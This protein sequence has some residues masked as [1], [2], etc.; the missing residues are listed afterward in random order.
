MPRKLIIIFFLLILTQVIFGQ[1]I[2]QIQQTDIPGADNT[3]PSLYVGQQ[4]TISPASIGAKG[5]NGS[6][7]NLFAYDLNDR[8]WNGIY[9]NNAT[10]TANLRTMVSITGTVSENNGMTELIN[11]TITV[12]NPGPLDETIA[13]LVTVSDLLNIATA[14]Q[15]E[16]SLVKINNLAC[17]EILDANNWYAI[18][19]SGN[20]LK[21]GA[22]FH[23]VNQTV[24]E[25]YGS[26]SGILV[27]DGIEF[28]LHPRNQADLIASTPATLTINTEYEQ[29]GSKFYVH[30]N[31]SNIKDSWNINGFE[32]NFNFNPVYLKHHS[33]QMGDISM[34]DQEAELEI[35]DDNY[36]ITYKPLESFGNYVT[37]R[38]I[39]LVFDVKE[40]GLIKVNFTSFKFFDEANNPWTIASPTAAN[41]TYN[42]IYNSKKAYLSIRNSRNDKNIFNPYNNERLIIKCGFKNGEDTKTIVRIYDLKGR[43][44]YTPVNKVVNGLL[45]LK[46]DGRDKNR[47]LV[48]IGTYICQVEVVIRA[49]GDKYTTDQPI[50]VAGQL[51]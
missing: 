2:M 10:N 20:E 36:K 46:W 11:A 33:T 3:Y 12:L 7:K 43:L 21:I 37:P 4:V 30:I 47:E 49:T 38:L 5:F 15:Y 32:F 16:S 8:L 35:T 22:G 28:V 14:E 26:I 42:N 34:A 19:G 27:Y 29:L 31:S 13:N 23:A 9:L 1:T 44:V 24:G 25:D 45:E 50:V 18:D 41:I 6:D 48:D 17:S 51:K 39:T 40:Y